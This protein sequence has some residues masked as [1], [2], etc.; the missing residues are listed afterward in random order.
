MDLC[1]FVSMS[2]IS[3]LSK[4]PLHKVL[5]N[6]DDPLSNK[7]CNLLIEKKSLVY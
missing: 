2:N 3:I 4:I 1:V 7:I 5:F 6:M